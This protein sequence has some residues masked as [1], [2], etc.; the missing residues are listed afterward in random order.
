MVNRCNS[1]ISTSKPLSRTPSHSTLASRSSKLT[2][3]GATGAPGID[4]VVTILKLSSP[5]LDQPILLCARTWTVYTESAS[6]PDILRW[7]DVPSYGS[8]CFS[9]H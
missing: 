7:Q 5:Q 9:K 3:F 2:T 1:N 6:K 4:V 8:T